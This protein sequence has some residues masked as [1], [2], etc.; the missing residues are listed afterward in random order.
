[1]V[2]LLVGGTSLASG[3]GN[4]NEIPKETDE[5]LRDEL[6]KEGWVQKNK[7]ILYKRITD[8]DLIND[9]RNYPTVP[10]VTLKLNSGRRNTRIKINLKKL[11][12]IDERD[13]REIN[14]RKKSEIKE[15]EYTISIREEDK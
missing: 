11:P 2:S 14:R 6:V 1:M 8:K 4:G 12:Q 9:L 10:R 5:N 15:D 7:N 3:K 13:K